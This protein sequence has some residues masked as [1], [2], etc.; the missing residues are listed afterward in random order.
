MES[1]QTKNQSNSLFKI[2][3]LFNVIALIFCIVSQTVNVYR[4]AII[5]AIFELFWLPIMAIIILI[6]FASIY[7]WYKDKFKVTSQFF[8]LLLLYDLSILTFYILT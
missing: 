1:K 2:I 5:G 7:Y 4:Y 6:P 3:L 8:Y